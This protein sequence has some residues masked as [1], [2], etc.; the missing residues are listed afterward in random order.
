MMTIF[1][2]VCR[3]DD[4]ETA[5]GVAQGYDM[6]ISQ[7]L[8]EQN[9]YGRSVGT[10]ATVQVVN[11]LADL[12]ALEEQWNALARDIP[13]PMVQFDWIISAAR[14]YRT[15]E[16]FIVKVQEKG[17]LQAVAPLVLRRH[18]LT[19]RL[20]CLGQE[21]CEPQRLVARDAQYLQVLLR[22]LSRVPYSLILRKVPADCS[23][24]QHF[25]AIPGFSLNVVRAN[26]DRDSYIP[27]NDP[28]SALEERMSASRRSGLRRKQKAAEKHGA[29][30]FTI[31]RPRPEELP[32]LLDEVF[33]VESSGWKGR[34]ETGLQHDAQRASF[35]RMYCERIARQGALRLGFMT[36]GE[37]TAAVR[38][39]VVWGNNS[40]EFKIG[41][42][43]RFADC[44][45]GLLLSHEALKHGQAE[46]LAGHYFLGD[47]EPWHDT[48]AARKTNRVTLR[49]YPGSV[50]GGITL[51]QDSGMHLWHAVKKRF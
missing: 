34:A 39:D 37:A 21:L 11:D 35:F 20:E 24:A 23:E 44:S 31:L 1:D 26:S 17:A 50:I 40:W 33:R 49:N 5:D 10:E 45:P 51:L 7:Q 42:D 41:F 2:R 48:W 29:V 32:R 19:R 6:Y 47:F 14:I 22:F 4:S 9:L 8:Q 36:I 18:G 38:L 27:L 25:G 46:G 16:L 3:W 12:E 30:K 28:S 13:W 43:E 15:G